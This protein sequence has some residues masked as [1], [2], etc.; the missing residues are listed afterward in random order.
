MKILN[1]NQ[2]P[3]VGLAATTFESARAL[4][5]S[6]A[7]SDDKLLEPVLVAWIDRFTARVSPVLEGC[8]G[9]DGWHDYGISHGGRPEAKIGNDATFIFAESSPFDSYEHFVPGP[10]VNIHDSLGNELICRT[11]GVDCVPLDEWTSKLT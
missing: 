9:Q 1:V 8:S 10:Y 2:P 6:L 7:E 4:A 5:F 11:G 3:F